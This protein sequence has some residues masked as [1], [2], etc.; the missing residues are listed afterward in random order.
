MKNEI[1]YTT[2]STGKCA[3]FANGKVIAMSFLDNKNGYCVKILQGMDRNQTVNKI[4]NDC[5]KF[6]NANNLTSNVHVTLFSERTSKVWTKY[7]NDKS[8]TL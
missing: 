3:V 5:P 7:Y 1:I 6:A 4:I 2:D 8:K